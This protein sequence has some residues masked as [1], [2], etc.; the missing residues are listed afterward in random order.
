META[1][2]V[3]VG[4]GIIGL[5]LARELVARGARVL[6]LEKEGAP[7]RHAS[8]RNSGVLHAGIYYAPGS[9]RA[10]SC[11]AGNRLMR[12]Y[13]RER[14]LPLEESGK[15]IV[16]K[17]H[18]EL[19]RLHA[20]FERAQSAGASVSLVDESELR[21]IEP[22]ARTVGRAIHSPLTAVVDPK[23]VLAGLRDDLRQSRRAEIRFNVRVHGPSGPG[24]LDTSAGRLAYGAMANASGAHADRLAHAFGKG[25]RYMLVPFKGLYRKLRPQAAHLV[26]GSVYP[27][28]DPA[29]PFLGV[30]F[31]RSVYGEVYLGP[32]AI[33]ALGRE[34][35]GLL[36]G[37]DAEAPSILWRDAMLFAS[38]PVFRRVALS[39][40]R[41][42]LFKHFFADAARLVD[43]LDPADVLP[44]PKAGIRPQLVDVEQNAMVMDFVTETGPAELHVL[45]AI[46]PAFTASMA[47]APGLADS[48]LGLSGSAGA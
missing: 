41:K 35:Y 17:C 22:H 34:N 8:G 4:A 19:P 18:E 21:E 39:E 9:A 13:C 6:V 45:N 33:P 44:S 46:S 10:R 11:L 23:A 40:P 16:T 14:G 32:T 47:M 38:S 20:L 1:E 42:Y 5:T 31:T 15:V 28:P 37:L 3:V 12:A 29:T 27:V 7:G 43:A 24:S 36:K 48:V 2:I 30:H 26:R 25:L